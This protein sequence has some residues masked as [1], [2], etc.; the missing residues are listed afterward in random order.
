MT[1]DTWLLQLQQ[2]C[3][4][5]PC[6]SLIQR[7]ECGVIAKLFRKLEEFLHKKAN[8]IKP[9]C[10]QIRNDIPPPNPKGQRSNFERKYAAINK[11]RVA[12]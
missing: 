3:K 7:H 2:K 11:L 4:S 1:Q 12:K 6:L 10:D 8:V 9:F 5:Q